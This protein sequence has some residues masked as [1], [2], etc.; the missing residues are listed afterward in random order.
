MAQPLLL[1]QVHSHAGRSRTLKYSSQR[2]PVL[3][4]CLLFLA[5][6]FLAGGL[7][8]RNQVLGEIHFVA[9]NKAAT[10]S[11]VW[12]DGQSVGY[13]KE[14]KGSRKVLLLPGKHRI[15]V[16]EAGYRKFTQAVN[17]EP[18]QKDVV[19]VAMR[20]DPEIHY[21]NETALVKLSGNPGRAAVFVD[22][23]YVGHV[24]QFNGHGQ[25]MLMTP[26][27]HDIKISMPGYQP[28]DTEVN[29]LP[30]QKLQIRTNLIPVASQ[31]KG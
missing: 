17:L 4:Q 18:G 12:V 21:S 27:Q 13:L 25:G 14:L 7:Q 11:G 1:C 16:R 30:H 23:R 10:N 22:K 8:A 26:G 31:T 5:P 15:E 29:L 2:I 3:L 19:R 20:K 9:A 28:F 24:D 6:L